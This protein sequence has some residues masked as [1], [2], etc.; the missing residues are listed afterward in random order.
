M[1][2][3]IIIFSNFYS[4]VGSKFYIFLIS[5][6]ELNLKI[7]I[8]IYFFIFIDFFSK[9]DQY[10]GIFILL[11]LTGYEILIDIEKN[12]LKIKKVET[13]FVKLAQSKT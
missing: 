11:S 7:K 6:D 8:L 12:S 13:E 4:P 9:L 1:F 3:I 5:L 2:F 10:F